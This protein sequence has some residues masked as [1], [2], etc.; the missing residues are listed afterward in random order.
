MAMECLSIPVA[1]A[2]VMVLKHHQKKIKV[3]YLA[4]FNIING[5]E[6]KCKYI[7]LSKCIEV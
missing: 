6:D 4:E 5:P 1:L 2:T 3:C 7:S